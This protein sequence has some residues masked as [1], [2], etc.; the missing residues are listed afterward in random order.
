MN[1]GKNVGFD[2]SRVMYAHKSG[3]VIN[4]NKSHVEFLHD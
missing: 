4:F 2:I 3:D 1:Q